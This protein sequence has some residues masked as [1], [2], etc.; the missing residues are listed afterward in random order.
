MRLLKRDRDGQ[1]CLTEFPVGVSI[2]S[3]AILS[4]TWGPL[5]GEVTFQDLVDRTG[6]DKAGYDKIRFCADQAQRHGL[7]YFWI[8]TCC[9]DRTNNAELAEAI[10]SMFRWYRGAARCYV[11]LPDVS[12]T[13]CEQSDW[14]SSPPWE[15][16]FR[17]SRW[18]TRGWTLQE[19]LAPASVEFFARGGT[20]LGSKMSL[21]QQIHEI[22]GIAVRA[23]RGDPLPGF[24]VE[25]RFKWAESRQTT[26]EED[27]AYSLLGIFSV[28]ISPIYGE[29][30]AH[31][32]RR[33]K[34]EINDTL[35]SPDG[36]LVLKNLPTAKGAAFD[37]HAEG[38][39]NRT[40][41]P[42]T[43]VD[44]LRQIDDWVDHPTAESIFW[45]NGMAGTGKS[46]ISRTVA[47]RC[48]ARGILGASF[49][50]KRG[51][52]DRGHAGLFFTTIA[53]QLVLKQPVVAAHV[54]SAIDSDP[55]ITEKTI[56]VQ[57]EK[58][59]LEPLSSLSCAS[60]D[61]R[62]KPT[63]PT[64]LVM[65]VD[66]LDECS[67]EEDVRLIIKLF[68]RS[69]DLQSPRLRIFVTSRPE[70]PTRLG[71]KD[72]KGKYQ[73]LVLHD[74]PEPVIEHDIHAYLASE[75]ATIKAD[76]D[77]SV[78][79]DRRLPADWPGQ[80][81]IQTLVKMATPLFI[82]AATV[83]R[84]LADRRCG[85]PDEQLREVIRY[86]TRSQESQLDATYLPVLEQLV[87]GL[88]GRKKKKL[89]G[90]FRYIIGSI[91]ILA[92]PLSTSSLAQILLISKDTIDTMLDLLHSVLSIPA[93][94]DAPVR[95]LHLSFCDFLVDPENQEDNDFWVDEKETHKRLAANC[96]RLL[97]KHLQADICRLTWP[98][99][100]QSAV[101]RQRI[102][103]ALPPEVQYACLYWT[104]HIEHA[105]GHLRDDDQVHDFLRR[106]FLH[107][108]EALS[109]MGRASESIGI[110][111]PLQ[112]LLKVGY[113][114]LYN[115]QV[116]KY[117]NRYSFS[118]DLALRYQLFF[119]I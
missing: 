65:V 116:N 3:Y 44:L 88:T 32:V 52:G 45:L 114:S 105:K 33:L 81:T 59:V 64:N 115:S 41:H 111:R 14:P 84:F 50:F 40:C 39:R 113:Q 18:F 43:R 10:N 96:L 22:T 58:L 100:L 25:E 71:F 35:S 12:A 26:R 56:G 70:L 89:L 77:D 68:S 46:T 36:H 104:H 37:T 20:L 85:N 48:D 13:S 7:V 66:A 107:W 74:M 86:Q 75:L 49:F 24:G 76:Y 108:L 53:A 54:K 60:Q 17:A 83:C 118:P 38:G 8:D 34:K 73:D 42:D 27:W 31:A 90:N 112:A 1:F 30:K 101:D 9:I 4:H 78:C 23:L 109:L 61:T 99:S 47:Q 51:E 16:A 29:G 69:N 55:A 82:F 91:V 62:K 93:L 19:L 11:Y 67:R 80:P 2:P 5:S 102:N 92:N 28:F 72:I 87:S 103:E 98:G 95:L 119:T 106:H 79:E 97:D 94:P 63:P 6:K 117:I 57:F 21:Q 110:I 15:S